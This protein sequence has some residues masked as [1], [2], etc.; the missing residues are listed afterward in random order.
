MFTCSVWTLTCTSWMT[1]KI[2]SKADLKS[3][4][5]TLHDARFASEDIDFDAKAGTFCLKCWVLDPK[6]KLGGVGPRWRANQLSFSNVANCTVETREVV[7]YYELATIRFARRN[8]RL[9]LV[10]HYGIEISL[11]IREPNGALIET[12]ETEENWS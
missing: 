4:G 1:T 9:E 8:G 7:S 5:A 11:Q 3:V 2:S 12:D 6:P 10:T